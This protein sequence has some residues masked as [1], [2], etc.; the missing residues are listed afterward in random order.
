[1]SRPFERAGNGS[2]RF[3]TKPMPSLEESP[4]PGS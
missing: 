3:Q 4:L 2:E 1:L